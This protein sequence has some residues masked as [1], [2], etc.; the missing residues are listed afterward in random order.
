MIPNKEQLEVKKNRKNSRDILVRMTQFNFGTNHN[1]VMKFKND[2]EDLIL[3]EEL[4]L[5]DDHEKLRF[6]MFLESFELKNLRA[7]GAHTAILIKEEIKFKLRIKGNGEIL[8]SH[9]MDE[10]E[11]EEYT[12]YKLLDGYVR[13]NRISK[14]QYEDLRNRSLKDVR[15]FKK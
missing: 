12:K 9:R 1:V 2:S 15:R 8:Y 3:T 6:S 7:L 11:L 13:D 10:A 5:N 14:E 4:D